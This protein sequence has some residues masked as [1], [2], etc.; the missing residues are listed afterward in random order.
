L[1]GGS[2]GEET[3]PDDAAAFDSNDPNAML[4]PLL[5]NCHANTCCNGT[6]FLMFNNA[7]S[8]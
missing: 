7:F 5:Q 8:C 1:I 3:N 6:S 4:L 2:V